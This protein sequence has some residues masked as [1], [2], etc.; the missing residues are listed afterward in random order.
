VKITGI[1]HHSVIVTDLDRAR[2]FYREALGLEEVPTPPAFDFPVAWFAL[3][4]EQ[5]HLLQ[6]KEPDARSGRHIA[7]HVK[8][9]G[10]ARHRLETL[11]LTV[12]DTAPIPGAQRFFTADPDG[13]RIEVIA[14]S[15]P[16][17]EA[18]QEPGL[19]VDSPRP[20]TG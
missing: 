16:W 11:G 4:E 10:A 6:A 13:N 12:A 3:G 17:T 8:D 15:R 5:L 2:A 14:R 20:G 7:L 19:R 9:I 18:V 1:H